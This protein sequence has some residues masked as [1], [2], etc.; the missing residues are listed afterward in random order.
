MTLDTHRS[1]RCGAWCVTLRCHLLV[2]EKV[3]LKGHIHETFGRYSRVGRVAVRWART[4]AAMEVD[5]E[6][7]LREPVPPEPCIDA[8]LRKLRNQDRAARKKALATY[9]EERLTLGER[10]LNSLEA[11]DWRMTRVDV[12][13]HLR[14]TRTL[15]ST[16]RLST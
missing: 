5:I 14:H 9:L 11:A 13:E 1:C 3:D 2:A 15:L 12:E 4:Q 8:E 16:V 10:L 7:L 6:A